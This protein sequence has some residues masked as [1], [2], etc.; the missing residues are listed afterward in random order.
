MQLGSNGDICGVKSLFMFCRK[1]QDILEKSVRRNMFVGTTMISK[2]RKELSGL[3]LI[4]GCW[5]KIILGFLE[6]NFGSM[7]NSNGKNVSS[8]KSPIANIINYNPYFNCDSSLAMDTMV[9]PT[10]YP[11]SLSLIVHIYLPSK[12]LETHFTLWAG[13]LVVD[14]T[15]RV[16]V[17][18]I[19]IWIV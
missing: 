4:S 12:I 16:R 18:Q 1:C 11:Y 5:V 6:M 9:L 14:V 3:N 15:S 2:N 19:F 13:S 8:I 10:P 17:W 7:S